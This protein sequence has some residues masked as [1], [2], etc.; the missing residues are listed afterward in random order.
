MVDPLEEQEPQRR[1]LDLERQ[2]LVAPQTL[3]RPEA[4]VAVLVVIQMLEK[5]GQRVVLRV[6]TVGS[7]VPRHGGGHRRN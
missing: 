7:P 3:F 1:E 2:C 6:E 5:I 4:D